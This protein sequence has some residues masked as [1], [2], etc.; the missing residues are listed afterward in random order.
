MPSWAATRRASSTSATLQ[1]PESDSPPHSLSVTPATSWPSARSRAAATDE[2]T[3]PLMATSTPTAS[4][5]LPYSGAKAAGQRGGAAG[6]QP[7]AR[8]RNPGALLG[9]PGDGGGEGGGH[10]DDAGHVMRAGAKIALLAAAVD[11][12]HEAGRRPHDQ[13]PDALGPA[14]LVGRDGDEGGIGR[15]RGHVEP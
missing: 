5:P 2:A 1:Q 3:P 15:R 14:E 8:G 4:A 9:P 7:G 13:G 6:G 10:A 12:R 11:D